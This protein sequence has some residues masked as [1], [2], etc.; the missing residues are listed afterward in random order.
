MDKM[1]VDKVSV[2]KV[3]VDKMSVDKMSIDK[4]SVDK[5]TYCHLNLLSPTSQIVT[6]I[7]LLFHQNISNCR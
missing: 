2:D 3:P 1:S 7:I 4:I 5:M 6:K